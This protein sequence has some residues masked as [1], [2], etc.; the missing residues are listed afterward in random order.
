MGRVRVSTD[1]ETIEPLWTATG[2]ERAQSVV[3][4][5]TTITPD[6]DGR[7]V[8]KKGELLVQIT[9]EDAVGPYAA[10]ATDG[11]QTP[12]I[13]LVWIA[14]ESIDL[15]GVDYRPISGWYGFC[16]FNVQELTLHDLAVATLASYMPT[17]LFR[18]SGVIATPA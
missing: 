1:Y 2:I 5:R 9:G 10:G 18:D 6:S 16:E 4:K 12:G 7:Y 8:V 15:S 14:T 3:V 13:G 17:C 11:R